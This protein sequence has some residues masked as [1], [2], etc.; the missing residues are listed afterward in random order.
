[1]SM[2]AASNP[3]ARSRVSIAAKR[4]AKNLRSI[5]VPDT[6]I[7][8]ESGSI[9]IIFALTAIISTSMVGGAIDFA[10]AYS[11]KSRLQEVVD[12][13]S[14]AAASAYVNDPNHDV[15]AAV[16]IGKRFFSAGAVKIPGATMESTLDPTSQTVT[17]TAQASLNLPFLSII[18]LGTISLNANSVVTAT[19]GLTG[20]GNTND[21]E[22]AMMLDTT[23]S[24]GSSDGTGQTKIQALKTAATN[25]INIL[26]PDQGQIHARIALAPF[27]PTVKLTDDQVVA[28]TG[29]SL[30][31]TTCTQTTTTNQCVNTTCKNYRSN[32]TCKT[33]NQSCTQVTTC[34]QNTT[35]YLS[36]C[37]SERMGAS[38]YTD[39][40]AAAGRFVGSRFVSSSSSA[41]NCTP[42]LTVVPLTQDKTQLK[43]TINAFTANGTTAGSLGTAWA[44]YLLSPSWDAVLNNGVAAG[45]GGAPPQPYGTA[46][47]KK[48]AIL[49]T[50]GTYNTENYTSYVEGGSDSVRISQNA[51]KLCQ[52]MK[53]KDI[54]VYTVGFKL[55]NDLARSTL[56]SC[57]T[58]PGH[59]FQAEDGD[60]LNAA[61]KEIAFRA[62]PI[63]VAQ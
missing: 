50:D 32:G 2:S 6:F 22:I 33:W 54:E 28:A 51:V 43:A 42:N 37:V 12:S 58:D 7:R 53:D 3:P 11:A 44:W 30:T 57:A 61:F 45:T 47:L 19:E 10:R 48:I 1:M 49:M 60:Q 14:L 8:D 25:L 34:T 5:F 63:H 17:M 23:G 26:I 35:T 31:K 21:V 29:E 38:Q 4:T 20:G 36:R 9:A 52:G 16:N 15:T 18:G 13:A 24:M 59:Y 39:E 55:D 40:P 56:S 41:N 46:K 27:A 62:V